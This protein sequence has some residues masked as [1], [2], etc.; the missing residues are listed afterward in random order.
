MS[1][2]SCRHARRHGKTP[3][4]VMLRWSLQ[5]G[6]VTIPKSSNAARIRE[7]AEVFDFELSHEEMARLNV[8]DEGMATG[9]NPVEDPE[10]K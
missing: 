4:Q 10:F 2:C 5:H 1:A 9:W 7:N 8:K 6:F 3:A